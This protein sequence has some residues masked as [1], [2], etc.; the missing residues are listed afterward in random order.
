MTKI[1]FINGDNVLQKRVTLSTQYLGLYAGRLRLSSAA[2]R[3][4]SRNRKNPTKVS[5]T[6]NDVIHP[7][8]LTPNLSINKEYAIK[9]SR[10]LKETVTA[11]E[12]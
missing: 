12:L 6:S 10:I 7:Q 1:A 8:P 3:S 2:P 11:I 9:D 4:G 5:I